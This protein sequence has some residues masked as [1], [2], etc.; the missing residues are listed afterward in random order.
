MITLRNAVLAVGVLLAFVLIGISDEMMQDDTPLTMDDYVYAALL[1]LSV[2][3]LHGALKVILMPTDR[4]PRAEAR[5]LRDVAFGSGG[6]KLVVLGYIGLMMHLFAFY[7]RNIPRPHGIL[8]WA[9][10]LIAL[11]VFD[12]TGAV[13]QHLTKPLML[14]ATEQQKVRD[15]TSRPGHSG[16]PGSP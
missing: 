1:A 13:V 16:E 6:H 11:G 12:Q 7:Q 8:Y 4:L 5:R 10:F 15:S 2:V 14:G 9:L 3:C